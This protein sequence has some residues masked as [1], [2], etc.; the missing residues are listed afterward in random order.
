MCHASGLGPKDE[1]GPPLA[2][3]E[4]C[5]EGTGSFITVRLS[6]QPMGVMAIEGQQG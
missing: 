5:K 4:Q 6:E 2:L 1:S 3:K